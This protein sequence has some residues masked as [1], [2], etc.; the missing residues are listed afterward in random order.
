MKKSAKI[1]A[2]ILSVGLVASVFSGCGKKNVDS[3]TSD[4]KYHIT[5]ANS[6]AIS[7]NSPVEKYLE[8]K[9]NVEIETKG[10]AANYYDKLATMFS[11]K[12]IP[13]V[14]F[15]NDISNWEPLVSQGILAPID[16]NT[17]KEAAPNHY[18]HIEEKNS[19]LWEVGKKNDTL[20]AIPK[21]M[22]DEYNTVCVWNNNWLKA[23]GI[24]KVPETLAEFEAAFD[25]IK[26]GDPDK[27][28][29]SDTYPISGIGGA[30]YRQFDWVFGAYGVMPEQWTLEN[31]KVV[32]G[33]VSN[34]AKEALEKLHDW[35]EK[36]YINPEFLTDTQDTLMKRFMQQGVGLVNT[37]L[38]NVTDLTPQGRANLASGPEGYADR[39]AYGPLPS[40]HNGDRGDWQWGPLS[41]FVCFGAQ[42]KDDVEKQKIILK[43]LDD[44]NYDEETALMAA[45]GE[46][47]KSYELY[48]E[49]A[50][51]SSGIKQ[52]GNY[53]KDA[54]A[55]AEMGI[56]FF[57]LLKCGAWADS[58]I[59]MQYQNEKFTEE[60][61]KYAN[62]GKYKDLLMRVNLPSTLT[63]APTL[64]TLKTTAYSEFINGKRSLSDWDKFVDEYMSSGGKTLRDE[65]QNYYESV[66]K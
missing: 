59:S 49:S 62:F 46:K 35:Y 10:F 55:N 64:Q 37:S 41:N 57:N 60:Q 16:I 29:K 47:G 19:K 31:G 45:Y 9:Y 20:Y 17:I 53:G 63:L 30:Y 54:N 14:M 23:L 24:D 4:G 26:N 22:G 18:K 1:T 36:G 21:S 52:L 5:I 8:N 6:V 40:G 48:D 56:G 11:T 15:I 32:N 27:N 50:G 65:A 38:D 34:K 39:I 66:I 44:L 3:K 2:A 42:L 13:D 25:K 28:G 7:D 12:D 33:T 61:K 58:S 43:I 51:K